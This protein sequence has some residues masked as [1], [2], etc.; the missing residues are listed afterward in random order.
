MNGSQARTKLL[1]VFLAAA[2]AS[3]S[4][5]YGVSHYAIAAFEEM[6]A[7]RTDVIVAQFKKEFVQREDEIAKLVQNIADASTTLGM[8]IDLARSK[9]DQSLY[10]H[11]AIVVAQERGLDFLD[12]V[13]WDGTV[14]SSAQYP[15]RAGQKEDWVLA[16]KDW[17]DS[18]AFLKIE[19]LPDG[20][21]LSLIAVRS[22]SGGNDKHLYVIG[23]GRIDHN[24]LSLLLLPPGMQVL[25][26]RALEP[27]F[28]PTNLTDDT[29]VVAQADRF[30][31]LIEQIQK[32]RQP[33]V[34]TIDW[35]SDPSSA[36]A[37]HV[38]PL[39]GRNRELLGALLVGSSL[40][41]LVLLK[42]R[43]VLI[44]AGVAAAALLIGPLISLS[45]IYYPRVR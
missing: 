31:S 38:R 26:Y 41:E 44:A 20:E 9:A 17:R 27:T 35:T 3:V 21:A 19:E 45:C 28:V 40:K 24:F 6:D 39:E 12:I 23:G 4:V 7:E 33:F 22:V 13:N 43:I 36:E 15:T 42:R 1:P 34:Q 32:R 10:A 11:D 25:L 14:I 30:A 8:A 29:A 16:T 18:R 5:A 2:L 37:F